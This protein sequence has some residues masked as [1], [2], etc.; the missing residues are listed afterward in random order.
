MRSDSK[1][2]RRLLSAAVAALFLS[3]GPLFSQTNKS[4]GAAPAQGTAPHPPGAA[5]PLASLSDAEI[6]ARAEQGEAAA[7]LHL[8]RKAEYS[9]VIGNAIVGNYQV[10]AEWYEKAAR[11]GYVPAMV[12]L[13]NLY[14]YGKL[15]RNYAE[16]LKWFS[17]AAE[18]GDP[19]AAERAGEIC[20]GILEGA[21]RDEAASQHWRELAA[22]LRAAQEK[23][24]PADGTPGLIKTDEFGR[25]TRDELESL[26]H[27]TKRSDAAVALARAYEEGRWGKPNYRRAAG[28]YWMVLSL[29]FPRPAEEDC[30]VARQGLLRL[31][32]R[33]GLKYE[34]RDLAHARELEEAGP[35]DLYYAQFAPRSHHAL[36]DFLS[37]AAERSASGREQFE[38]GEMFYAGGAVPENWQR[39]VD[40]FAEAARRDVPE[41]INR[42]GEMWANGAGGQPDPK[43]A[44]RWFMRAATNGLPSAQ[45]NLGLAYLKGEGLERN[46]I[47][48]YAWLEVASGAGNTVAAE[49]LR[50]MAG[51]LTANELQEARRLA[52]TRRTK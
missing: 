11:Q 51:K 45:C 48:A 23:G 41:A 32:L 47:E 12:P 49:Q 17:Q 36:G 16:A 27:Q 7:Q 18:K 30:D 24:A 22:R 50:G 14:Y 38:I 34:E 28:L 39:A 43:E 29:A 21:K 46:P 2:L 33:D 10:A 37:R 1:Q 44:C 35:W 13:A 42:L 15:D 52:A 5:S 4:P 40:C 20:S 26:V 25:L 6:E 8:G 9:G 3:S 31:Y 19:L